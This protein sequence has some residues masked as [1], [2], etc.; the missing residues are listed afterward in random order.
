MKFDFYF[1]K[2]AAD[3]YGEVVSEKLKGKTISKRQSDD[4]KPGSLR[5]EANN[6]GI[7]G[8]DMW[9]LLECLEGMCFQG[10]AEEIDDSHYLVK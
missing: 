5:F 10:L 8:F 3:K 4:G 1:G 9:K 2:D 7:E 6:L